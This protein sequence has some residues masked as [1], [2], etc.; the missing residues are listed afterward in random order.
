MKLLTTDPRER[1][2]H[3]PCS[4]TRKRE[5]ANMGLLWAL[6]VGLVI[7]AL[8]KLL[9]PG[10]DGGGFILTS[11]LGVAGSMVAFAIGRVFGMYGR[12]EDGPGIL[13]SV[14]GAVLVLGLYRLFTRR[15]RLI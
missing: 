8:A 12:Y 4:T 14:L 3:R 10:R 9:M 1:G 11:L 13:A 5:E 6:I 2:W 15:R 7:G